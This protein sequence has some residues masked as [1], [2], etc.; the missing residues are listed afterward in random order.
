MVA[1][2]RV[3]A[4]VAMPGGCM[5][6]LVTLTGHGAAAVVSLASVCAVPRGH[7]VLV[8]VHIVGRSVLRPD[9]VFAHDNSFC[10]DSNI[11]PRGSE[12][13]RRGEVGIPS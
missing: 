4:M 13:N 7:V 10:P 12:W 9:P 11:P 8:V 1:V 2:S 3:T 5:A 6:C